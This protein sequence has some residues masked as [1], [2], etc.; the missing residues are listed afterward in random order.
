MPLESSRILRL[1]RN[2]GTENQEKERVSGDKLTV[3]STAPKPINILPSGPKVTQNP[4]SREDGSITRGG[5]SFA[6]DFGAVLD[7]V[8][9][10]WD[11][12]GQHLERQR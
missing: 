12:G 3:F 10:I 5:M 9:L 2:K 4:C 7:A 6:T 11:L 1:R 8:A